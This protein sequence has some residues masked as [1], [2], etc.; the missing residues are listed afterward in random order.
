ML[1]TVVVSWVSFFILQRSSFAHEV[2]CHVCTGDVDASVATP[3]CQLLVFAANNVDDATG[4]ECRGIQYQGVTEGCCDTPPEFCN[5]CEQ[6]GNVPVPDELASSLTC[7]EV[8]GLAAFMPENGVEC[9]DYQATYGVYCGCDNPVAV[10]SSSCNLCQ[11]RGPI[12]HRKE[13]PA[14]QFQFKENAPADRFCG[15]LEY[16]AQ[17]STNP[18]ATCE[19][20]QDAFANDCCL[21]ITSAPT[22]PLTEAPAI[23][24]TNAPVASP[25]ES[26]IF[27]APSAP[28]GFPFSFSV[29]VATAA[30]VVSTI[31]A[32]TPVI[33][34]DGAPVASSNES[35][36]ATTSDVPSM[37]PT[38]T[39]VLSSSDIPSMVPTEASIV[40]SSDI[41]SMFPTIASLDGQ[42]PFP[43]PAGSFVISFPSTPTVARTNSPTV[44]MAAV[45][46]I[47]PTDDASNDVD[48]TDIPTGNV[49]AT[50]APFAIPTDS[51]LISFAPVDISFGASVAPMTEAPVISSTDDPIGDPT[52]AVTPPPVIGQFG[53]QRLRVRR[54]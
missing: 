20:Y 3:A 28:V 39:F 51:F 26:H 21:P 7:S 5:L 6:G 15:V 29:E 27:S 9:T 8:G 34:L 36:V 14:P 17:F 2:A 19:E 41:P 10:Q 54:W 46:D 48:A 16:F 22:A 43:A 31:S 50:T 47:A 45:P 32:N 1:L 40:S 37:V 23:T 11:N 30:P 53:G 33:T 25:M 38:E 24:L 35:F 18:F 42:A 44:S 4:D 52:E 12:L 49:V 13:V